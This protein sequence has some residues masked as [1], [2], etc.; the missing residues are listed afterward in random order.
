MR[1]I[2]K[3][4]SGAILGGIGPGILSAGIFVFVACAVG[5]GATI[6]TGGIAGIAIGIIALG[7]LAVGGA[8]YKMDWTVQPWNVEESRKTQTNKVSQPQPPVNTART[9]IS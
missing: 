2:A 4:V 3:I 7:A 1:A 5:L 8:G 9:Y 6:G